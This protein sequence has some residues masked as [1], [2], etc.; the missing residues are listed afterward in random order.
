RKQR[1]T[2]GE[3]IEV[4]CPDQWMPHEAVVGPSL[5]IRN[6]EHN[7][8]WPGLRRRSQAIRRAEG[9]QCDERRQKV[10]VHGDDL[11]VVKNI[12][13]ATADAKTARVRAPTDSELCKA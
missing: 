3:F 12:A 11:S 13:R 1:A 8:W 6:D 4:R 9:E 2:R 7:V 10:T 5:V